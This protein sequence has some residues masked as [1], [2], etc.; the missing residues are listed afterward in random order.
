MKNYI[1]VRLGKEGDVQFDMVVDKNRLGVIAEYSNKEGYFI[2]ELDFSKLKRVS[3][4]M[5]VKNFHEGYA[6]AVSTAN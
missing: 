5:V 3:L 2:Y 1:V 6:M 4:E